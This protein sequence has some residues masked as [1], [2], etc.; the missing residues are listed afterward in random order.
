MSSLVIKGMRGL[1]DNIYQRAFVRHFPGAY[2]ETPWPEVYEGLDVRCV[3]A[4]TKL[5]T[6]NDNM[7]RTDYKWHTPPHPR[8]VRAMHVG[9]GHNDL[10]KYGIVETMRRLFQKNPLFGLPDFREFS[11]IPADRDFAMIRPVTIRTEWRN[12][13]RN[14]DPSY[15]AQ[16]THAMRKRGLYTVS[17]A[18][19]APGAEWP[20]APLPP[21][22]LQFHSG[23]L[24]LRALLGLF[25]CARLVLGGVGWIVPA[26][27][28]T[29]VPL[30]II[31]G[32]HGAH[33]APSRIL[34]R[35]QDFPNIGWAEPEN[36]CHCSSMLHACPKYIRNFDEKFKEWLDGQGF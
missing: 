23:E 20:V 32:G 34:P 3:R 4:V 6:Q 9:Y 8:A 26:A 33:N 17:V 19:F 2:I 18:S 22:D 14:P 12:E 1:G 35:E 16:A 25:Q 24:A 31:Q 11:P 21:A 5:R 7:Q 28:A 36:F 27:I 30:F 10:V 13:A 15:L 29:L